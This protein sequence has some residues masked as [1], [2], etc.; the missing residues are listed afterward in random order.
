MSRRVYCI[1]GLGASGQVFSRL[2]IPGTELIV[3]KWLVPEQHESFAAYSRRMFS[4]VTDHNPVMIGVSFGGMTCIEIANQF[5]LK[6]LLL[7]SSVKT[8]AELPLWM[9]VTGKLHL[10]HL[11]QPRPHPFLYPVE[12]FFLGAGSKEEKLI[13]NSFRKE[14]NRQYL[15]WA[16]HQIVSW[17]NVTIPS[18]ITHIHGTG[19]RL[20]P[21][22]NIKADY[23]I[24]QGG[25]FMVYNKAAEIST[26]IQREL[27]L[28]N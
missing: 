5:P 26:I 2:H 4:Q 3:L 22:R 6:K 20:F 28:V 7:I 14:V 17:K 21:F 23:T 10:H 13:A 25:H 1:S 9:K 27:E 11:L 19:D 24:R 12:N 16:I 18:N 8:K 15:Q